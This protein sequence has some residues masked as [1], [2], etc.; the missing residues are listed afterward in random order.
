[1]IFSIFTVSELVENRSFWADNLWFFLYNNAPSH[2][3]LVLRYHFAKNWTHI[4]PQ[5]LHSP[6]LAPCDDIKTSHE[7]SDGE[8]YEENLE[9]N[10]EDNFEENF[11]E[12]FKQNFEDNL[13]ENFEEK[14]EENQEGNLE[15]KFEERY[16]REILE[17]KPKISNKFLKRR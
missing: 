5:P 8:N 1:M 12:K 3:A 2:T 15:E 11:E 16:F 14:F 13:V 6:D 4:V 9:G 10:F 7:G 17:T